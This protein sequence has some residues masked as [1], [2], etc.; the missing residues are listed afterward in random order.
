MGKDIKE[1]DPEKEANK[2]S[3][4]GSMKERAL[5]GDK[6]T[7]GARRAIAR[8]RKRDIEAD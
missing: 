7:R 3:K 6:L 2:H 1:Q 5:K 8:Q 4:A